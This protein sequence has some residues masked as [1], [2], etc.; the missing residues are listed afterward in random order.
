MNNLANRIPKPV[1]LLLSLAGWFA[2]V[3]QLVLFLQNS[4]VSPGTTIVRYFVFFTILTNI[5]AAACSSVL[6][7]SPASSW[8]QFFGKASTL[9]AITVYIVIVGATYNLILRSL[10]APEGLQRLVD[11]LLHSVVP[12]LFLISWV[13]FVNKRQL[14]WKMTPSWLIYPIVY[15]LVVVIYGEITGYYP[16]PFIDVAKL[17]YPEALSNGGIIL[18]AFILLSLLLA[19][20]G[21]IGK[22]SDDQS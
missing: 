11:E 13:L 7:L 10:W 21:R 19:S 5:I 20:T 1:L 18:L 4:T 3:A 8:G 15:I 16:Y 14:N 2:L 9:T 6:L 12:L 22:K 17:G